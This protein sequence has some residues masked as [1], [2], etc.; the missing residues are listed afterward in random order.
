LNAQ[1]RCLQCRKGV[2]DGAYAA[3]QVSHSIGP[4]REALNVVGVQDQAAA[5]VVFQHKDLL[6]L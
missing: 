4:K 3:Q 1:A 2:Q 5:H 6:Y